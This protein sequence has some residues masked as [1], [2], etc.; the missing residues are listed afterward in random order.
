MDKWVI[1]ET[2]AK[3]CEGDSGEISTSASGQKMFLP[4]PREQALQKNQILVSEVSELEN[5]SAER[6]ENTKKPILNMDL[7]IPL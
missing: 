6:R 7:H 5:L 4:L 3:T 1:R 2:T